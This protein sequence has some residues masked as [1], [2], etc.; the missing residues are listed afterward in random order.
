MKRILSPISEWIIKDQGYFCLHSMTFNSLKKFGQGKI[1]L[2]A[3][4]IA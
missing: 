2:C 4:E 1:L 3:A